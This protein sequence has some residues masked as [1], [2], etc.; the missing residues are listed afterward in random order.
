[1]RKPRKKRAKETAPRSPPSNPTPPPSQAM[2]AETLGRFWLRVD[3]TD[4]CWVWIGFRNRDG[5][6]RAPFGGV[7][8][9]AHRLSWI[10]HFGP[11]P[12]KKL[13][14]HRCDV[15]ACVRP[16]HLFVGTQLDNMIDMARKGRGPRSIPVM[17]DDVVR[18]IRSDYVPGVVT[19][20]QI[21]AKYG[22]TTKRVYSIVTRRAWAHV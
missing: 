17:T 19:Q 14:C 18:A 5:Y 22:V 13:I 16:D 2:L 12:P 10:L 3:K 8:H 4:D 1:M 20:K 21:A 15:P 11:I 9:M 6:G 7:T